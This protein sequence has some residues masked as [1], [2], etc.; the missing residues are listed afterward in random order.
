MRVAAVSASPGRDL[1]TSLAAVDRLCRR[2]RDG[3]ADLL[4]LPESALGGAFGA[5]PG[6]RPPE[7][8]LDGETVQQLCALAGGLVVCLGVCERTADGEVFDTAL[9]LSGDGVHGEHRNVHA[10]LREAAEHAR[11]D[12][13]AAFDT[14]VGRLGLLVGY[15][16]AFPEAGRALALDGAELVAVCA[17]WA[18]D[19]DPAPVLERDR[20]A[21]LLDLHVAA[22]AVDNQ[23]FVAAANGWGPVGELRLLGRAQVVSPSGD[24]LAATGCAAGMALAEVDL[25]QVHRTRRALHHLRD[26][27]PDAYPVGVPA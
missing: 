5:G 13:F 18:A 20:Q 21:R 16:A 14:P 27:R 26:R 2:A 7:L 8:D 6:C 17:A 9:C 22:R 11:G 12:R 3:E 1:A 15:D 10:P 4:L 23:V 24:V 25:A 19:P